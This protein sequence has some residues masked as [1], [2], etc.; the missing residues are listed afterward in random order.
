MIA[1]EI[2][3]VPF[4]LLPPSHPRP[5]GAGKGGRDT[6]G[7][8][9]PYLARPAM[10]LVRQ[11]HCPWSETGSIPVQAATTI[12]KAQPRWFKAGWRALSRSIVVRV[13]RGA[14][15]ETMQ[16]NNVAVTGTVY[17][18]ACKAVTCG[19][20]SRLLLHQML[21]RFATWLTRSWQWFEPRTAMNVRSIRTV[22]S[23]FAHVAQQDE[24]EITN[25]GDAGSSPAVSSS[26]NAAGGGPRP[27]RDGKARRQAPFAAVPPAARGR[28]TRRRLH[29]PTGPRGTGIPAS[30]GRRRSV[31]RIH[32]P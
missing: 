19:F 32:L 7:P 26:L 25:L 11:L 8:R 20:E 2:A 21:N 18:S 31:V 13:H 12:R 16:Q 5:P 10:H 6:R 27:V 30:L 9:T 28:R 24:Y 23:T 22:G 3:D 17:G 4:A 14:T 1:S 15:S 29:S